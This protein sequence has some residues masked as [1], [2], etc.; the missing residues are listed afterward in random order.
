MKV[1]KNYW[2]E[3]CVALIMLLVSAKTIAGPYVEVGLGKNTNLTACSLCWDDNGGVGALLGAGYIWQHNKHL[4]SVLHWTHLSHLDIGPPFN[5]K[6]E[7]VV[8]HVG[9]KLVY[10]W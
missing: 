3:V 1:V 8:D 10:E 2:L 9:F 7:S 6:Q 5:D 4:S